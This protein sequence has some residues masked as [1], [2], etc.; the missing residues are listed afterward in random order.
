MIKSELLNI[1]IFFVK[2]YTEVWSREIFIIDS[3]LKKKSLGL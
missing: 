2:Y 3:V 1:R